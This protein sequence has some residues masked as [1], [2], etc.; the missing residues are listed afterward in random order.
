MQQPDLPSAEL[1]VLRVLWEH[2]ASTVRQV[3]DR[4]HAQGRE[5]AYTT[6]LTFLTRLEQK[7]FVRSDKSGM[8][9][10]YAPTVTRRTVT[11]SR[12]RTLLEELYDGAAAP[13]VLQLMKEERFTPDEIRQFQDLVQ[14]IERK[15]V[16]GKHTKGHKGK[17]RG[18]S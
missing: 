14:S 13:L 9:Y 3:L 18:K 5:I 1:E 6:V 11:K 2:G 8:A 17:R 16:P 4:L 7:G 10:V 15:D 12:L